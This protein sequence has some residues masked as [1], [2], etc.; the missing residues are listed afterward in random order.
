[1]P[2]FSIGQR[3]CHVLRFGPSGIHFTEQSP[4][5]SAPTTYIS[6][7]SPN[8]DFYTF[9]YLYPSLASTSPCFHHLLLHLQ[10][11]PSSSTHIL[12]LLA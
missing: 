6:L 7:P 12:V 10:L 5:P 1:M 9:L 2:L 3:Y 4:A 11:P 8:L